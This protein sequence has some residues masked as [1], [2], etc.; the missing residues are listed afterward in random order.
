MSKQESLFLKIFGTIATALVIASIIGL[1]GMYYTS[2]IISEKTLQNE[3]AI[4]QL[5]QYHKEDVQLIRQNITDIKTD[6]T[7]IK[8]DI[9]QILKE[10]K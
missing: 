4:N 10:V 7:I 6:Q 2:G 5:R 1:I 3:K 9:K 8:N